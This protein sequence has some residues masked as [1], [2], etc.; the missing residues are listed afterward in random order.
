ME[1]ETK[2]RWLELCGRA[3]AEQDP[4]KLIAM[5]HEIERLLEEKEARLRGTRVID[6]S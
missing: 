4:E 5:I 1:S 2:E 3:A 6:G